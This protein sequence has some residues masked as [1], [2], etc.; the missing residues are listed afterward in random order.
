MAVLACVWLGVTE[1]EAAV[2][3]ALQQQ[4]NVGESVVN[5]KNDLDELGQN[6]FC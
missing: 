2:V 6:R 5:G 3:E 1:R 4:N